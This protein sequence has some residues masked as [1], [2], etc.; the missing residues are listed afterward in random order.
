[1]QNRTNSN[2]ATFTLATVDARTGRVV[3]TQQMRYPTFTRGV[4]RNPAPAGVACSVCGSVN[5]PALA[6]RCCAK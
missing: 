4:D 6:A 1:M 5:V 3:A 2:P